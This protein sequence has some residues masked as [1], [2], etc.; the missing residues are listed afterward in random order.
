MSG[1]GRVSD[2]FKC[3]EKLCMPDDIYDDVSWGSSLLKSNE[4]TSRRNANTPIHQ[5]APKARQGT[6]TNPL[7]LEAATARSFT[8]YKR[9][10]LTLNSFKPYYVLTPF[11]QFLRPQ[12]TAKNTQPI[13]YGAR[14]RST[15]ETQ[16]GSTYGYR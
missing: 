4:S 3:P 11:L 8:V 5:V 15:S 16:K 1:L 10:T 2:E 6:I 14:K 7:S 13:D 12:L 9:T